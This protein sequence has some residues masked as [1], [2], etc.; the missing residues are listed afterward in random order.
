MVIELSRGYEW[1]TTLTTTFD[2]YNK[3]KIVQILY[4]VVNKSKYYFT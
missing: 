1:K 4:M 2:V 3:N